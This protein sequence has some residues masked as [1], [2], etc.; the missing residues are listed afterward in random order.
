VATTVAPGGSTSFT[1]QFDPSARGTFGG[2]LH[3]LNSD[4]DETSFDLVLSGLATAP[5]IS[6]FVGGAE[7]SSGGLVE[8]DTTQM[9]TPV[10][11][12][13]TVTNVGD[14]VLTLAPIDP[15]T[16]PAGFSLIS[17][18][19]TTT[20]GPGGTATFTVQLNA[21]AAGSFS[22]VIHITSDDSD[23]ASFALGLHGAVNDPTPPP[24]PPPYVKTIDN[25]ADGF[26]A[27]GNWHVQNSKGG[28]EQDIQF[29]NKAEKNDKTLSTA[30]WT[31]TGL[32]AGQYRVSVTAPAS[33]SYASDAPFS[34]FDGATLLKTVPVNQRS[35][36]GN[37]SADGFRW[38]NLGTFSI[39][40]GTL[41]VQLTNRANGH[42]VADAVKIERVTTPSDPAAP[43][44]SAKP[45]PDPHHEKDNGSKKDDADHGSHK[46]SP[47]KSNSHSSPQHKSGTKPSPKHDDAPWLDG[48]AKDVAKHQGSK[49]RK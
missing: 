3:L 16:L 40:G 19:S 21:A 39:Q 10:T 33:P 2:T 17:G 38:Q 8:F 28:F 22:G 48:L 5:E 12:T 30:T 7:V 15:N 36:L 29:A 42:V 20:L 4:A 44:P 9:G 11:R 45:N 37:C 43:S 25:G 49:P 41:I 27:T 46:P 26:A 47:H 13:I 34:V 1:V 6:V 31:F 35:T 24:P 14:A 23:E 18:L 32:A